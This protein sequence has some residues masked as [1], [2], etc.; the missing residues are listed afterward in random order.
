MWASSRA[1]VSAIVMLALTSVLAACGGG[2]DTVVL[3]GTHTDTPSSEI[4]L[5]EK[6]LGA[7]P[8]T[9]DT[10]KSVMINDYAAVR[11]IFGVPLPG[12]DA[13]LPVLV[14]YLTTILGP[15]NIVWVRLSP[16]CTAKPSRIPECNTSPSTPETW[17]KAW[18][19]V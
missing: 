19:P 6:L 12:P 7:I 17:T 13:D 18:K 5:F 3:R 2:E 15:A 16:A 1:V 10:R 11:E 8:D 14:E 9:P 4:S